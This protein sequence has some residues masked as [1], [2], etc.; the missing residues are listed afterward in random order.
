[1]Y[2]I[3]IVSLLYRYGITLPSFPH[4]FTHDIYKY[5]YINRIK[6]LSFSLRVGRI[7]PLNIRTFAHS[8]DLGS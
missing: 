4:D 2:A 6:S 3:A 8:A 1:M 7:S 5:M